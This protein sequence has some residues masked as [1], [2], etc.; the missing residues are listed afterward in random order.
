MKTSTNLI[1]YPPGGYGTFIEWSCAYFS[2]ITKISD[3]FTSNGSCHA[4]TGFPLALNKNLFHFVNSQNPYP[5]ARCHPGV[6]QNFEA[7]NLSE[8]F[9][10]D[11]LYLTTHFQKILILYPTITSQL[12]LENN[13]IQKTPEENNKILPFIDVLKLTIEAEIDGKNLMQWNKSTINDFSIWELRELLSE[14]W[15]A[16]NNNF[17]EWDQLKLTNKNSNI[18][19][20]SLDSLRDNF[21]ETVADYL[22]FFNI[23]NIN[24]NTLESLFL[25]WKSGQ[26]HLYKDKIVLSIID[27]VLNKTNYH[28]DDNLTI[29]DEAFIQKELKAKGFD[30]KCFNL[31]KF[32]TNTQD[33]LNFIEPL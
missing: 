17:N 24:I 30:L 3:P 1:Y 16:R 4:Y 2:G 28:W 26:E 23:T 19:F 25:K 31:N 22:D 21:A 14:Y 29:L 20:V 10:V 32:P 18:K 6:I 12:L 5:Y 33:L 8:S 11:M 7:V 9:D 13:S 27:S 15:F